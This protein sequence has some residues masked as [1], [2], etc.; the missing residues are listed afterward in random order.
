MATPRGNDPNSQKERDLREMEN[1]RAGYEAVEYR[2]RRGWIAWGWI[3]LLILICCFLWFA[4]WGWGGYGGWWGAR[5]RYLG[6]QAITGS[7]AAVLYSS[8]KADYVGQAFNLENAPVQ[9]EI[10]NRVFWVGSA[11]AAPMLVVV[12]TTR[13]S[14]KPAIRSG[15]RISISGIVEKAPPAAEAQHNWGLSNQGAQRLE[16]QQAYLQATVVQRVTS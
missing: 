9:H 13:N 14:G 15:E 3:W 10:N 8:T 4:G 1:R 12:K 6:E 11:H 7:G 2:R 16:Q 5:Q